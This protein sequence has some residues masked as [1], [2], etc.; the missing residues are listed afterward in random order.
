M[1]EINL[2]KIR[3]LYESFLFKNYEDFLSVNLELLKNEFKEFQFIDCKFNECSF[4]LN[5]KCICFTMGSVDWTRKP[6]EIHLSPMHLEDDKESN[7]DNKLSSIRIGFYPENM[8]KDLNDKE[9]LHIKSTLT[10]FGCHGNHDSDQFYR[11][12]S[13]SDFFIID[14]IRSINSLMCHLHYFYNKADFSN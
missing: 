10:S 13:I 7:L 9:K 11:I 5:H 8:R 3:K 4:N 1:K 2:L 12:K 6:L 14:E